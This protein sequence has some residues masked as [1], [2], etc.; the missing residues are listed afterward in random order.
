MTGRD[1]LPVAIHFF[2][3]NHN[4]ELYLHAFG[5]DLDQTSHF[6]HGESMYGSCFFI[7]LEIFRYFKT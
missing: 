5:A 7:S 6:R 3:K 1:T 4:F 2:V